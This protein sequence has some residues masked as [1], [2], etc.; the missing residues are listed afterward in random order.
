MYHRDMKFEILSRPAYSI[1][2]VQLDPGEAIEAEPG[3]MVAIEGSVE[4]KTQYRGIL[5]A[6]VGQ[7]SVFANTYIA[8][9]EGATIWLAPAVPGDIAY[10]ELRGDRGVIISDK[11]YLAHHGDLQFS[12]VWKGFKGLFSSGGLAWLRVT[13]TG[14]IWVSAY[15]S[16]IELHASPDKELIVDNMHLVAMDDTVDFEIKKFGGLKTMLFG[17]EGFVFKIRGQGRVLIQ[18][19]NPELWYRAMSEE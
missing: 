9:P 11:C 2:K 8:G 5:R 14:G 13:G 15:G 19:R 16:I 12:V 7:E 17:G 1:L 18:S 3:A 6:I 4:V 10:I